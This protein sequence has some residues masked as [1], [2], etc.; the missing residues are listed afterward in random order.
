M[1]N[2]KRGYKYGYKVVKW[3]DGGYISCCSLKPI[4]YSQYFW[5]KPSERCGPLAVFQT[6]IQAEDFLSAQNVYGTVFR[7]KY[8]P[9][10]TNILFYPGSLPK[11][12]DQCPSGTRFANAVKLL[13]EQLSPTMLALAA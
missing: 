1:K 5:V 8:I 6:K 7:C 9:S 13:K 11:Y 12:R 2:P 10:K 4:K 3:D